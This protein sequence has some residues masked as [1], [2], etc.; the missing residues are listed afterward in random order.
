LATNELSITPSGVDAS[1]VAQTPKLIVGF[2]FEGGQSEVW[3]FMTLLENIPYHKKITEVSFVKSEANI[4]KA[5]VKMQL[6]LRY[7]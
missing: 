5:N 4:W 3:E 1:G 7:D 2:S 6:T